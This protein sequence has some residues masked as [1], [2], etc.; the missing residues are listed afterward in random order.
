MVRAGKHRALLQ[1][2]KLCGE[3]ISITVAMTLDRLGHT[4]HEFRGNV[5]G[6]Q[7]EGRATVTLEN[8]KKIEVRGMPGARR[9][10]FI[11]R[12]PGLT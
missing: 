7:I 4:W 2:I 1:D 11:L 9:P 5:H 8:D 3:D 10:Q 12:P 6:D